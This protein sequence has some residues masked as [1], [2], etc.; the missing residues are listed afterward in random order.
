MKHKFKTSST[1]IH[2][3]PVKINKN[4]QKTKDFEER[5]LSLYY[6][7]YVCDVFKDKPLSL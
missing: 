4:K 1:K 2:L 6:L 5:L 7:T 3:H